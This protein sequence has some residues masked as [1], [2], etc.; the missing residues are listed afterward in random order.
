VP[1]VIH[2]VHILPFLNVGR[3]ESVAYLGAERLVAPFT[4]LFVNV[5]EAMRDIGI[6]NRVGRSDHHVVVPSGMDVERFRRATPVDDAVLAAAFG[7]PPGD[8][9]RMKVVLIVAAL[10]PRKRI[11]EFLDVFDR[12]ARTEPWARLVVLGEGADRTRIHK[13][14][15]ALGLGDQVALVGFR[16]D[17][18]RWIARADV[19]VFASARE[20]LPRAVVQ[21]ALGGRP[22]VTTALPGIEAVVR[23]GETGYLVDIDKL[24]DMGQPIL[25]LLHDAALSASMSAA[26]RRMDLSRWSI[27]HMVEALDELYA[28]VL[29]QATR[30]VAP[31]MPGRPSSTGAC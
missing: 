19:C 12:I 30:H 8:S 5:S 21:Y 9:R 28:G 25:R 10:E 13:R 1:A 24:E 6:A 29:A 16:E 14:A 3:A 2:G 31:G 23:N 26:T 15:S 11:A 7:A 22:V 18:E 20:G 17:V 4:D 27:E